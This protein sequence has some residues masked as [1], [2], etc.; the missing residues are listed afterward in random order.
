MKFNFSHVKINKGP[1]QIVRASKTLFD[2]PQFIFKHKL[3]KGFLDNSWVLLVSVII[4]SAFTYILYNDI[5]DYFI[6]SE[7]EGIEINISTEDGELDSAEKT[8]VNAGENDIKEL[9]IDKQ[10]LIS[11]EALKDQDHG[12]LFSGSLKFLLL[13]FLEVLIFHFSV[14]T[15]NILKNENK[16]LAFK[17]LYRA[18]IRMIKVMAHKWLYGLL[19]YVFISIICGITGTDYLKDTLMFLIYGFYLG[20]A[21]LDNYL[22]QYHF[23]I[24]D[25]A[26]AVQTHF[27]A[28]TV[29]GVFT[30]IVMNVPFIGPL[31]VPFLCGIAATR[32][33]HETKIENF[34]KSKKT[35]KAKAA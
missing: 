29:F 11:K 14:R 22:E 13:I 20:F 7:Q 3:W 23:N 10:D 12:S 5:H 8:K 18:Q 21:F 6:P 25:S 30:S 26:R 9:V 2:T 1:E 15:N 16:L 32:Y 28:A 31:L 24:Y 19:M 17:D 33:G 34:P 4:A 35:I 27:G